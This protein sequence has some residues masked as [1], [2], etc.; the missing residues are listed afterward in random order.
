MMLSMLDVAGEGEQLV[1]LVSIYFCRILN[2]PPLHFFFLFLIY[3]LF[4]QGNVSACL[5]L[6]VLFC[7]KLP[8]CS[9]YE[10]PNPRYVFSLLGFSTGISLTEGN[11]V[12]DLLFSSFPSDFSRRLLNFLSSHSY[13]LSVYQQA[14]SR[15]RVV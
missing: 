9:W 12:Y 7:F 14:C 8:C 5:S 1:S 10:L 13:L 3:Y 6:L 2:I 15:V 4:L 11:L